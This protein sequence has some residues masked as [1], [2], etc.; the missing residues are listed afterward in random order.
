MPEAPRK[1]LCERL[2][3]GHRTSVLKHPAQAG[4]PKQRKARAAVAV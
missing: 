4:K 3:E 2:A 1:R